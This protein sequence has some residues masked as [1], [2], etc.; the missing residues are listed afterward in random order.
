M[1]STPEG[2]AHHIGETAERPYAFPHPP[3]R[4][5]QLRTTA[6]HN[7]RGTLRALVPVLFALFCGTQAFAQETARLGVI[8]TDL[9]QTESAKL[10]AGGAYVVSATPNGPAEAAGILAKDV[11]LDFAGKSIGNVHDLVCALSKKR[12]GDV[13]GLTVLRNNH[14]Q[15]A[16]VTLGQWPN[17]SM[18]AFYRTACDV[19]LLTLP[20]DES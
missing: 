16:T 12:P 15:F 19:V 13:V 4:L 5:H 1:R 20:V 7:M 14:S 9:T 3:T 2:G 10:G 8:V 11:I 6:R 17:S 18:Q